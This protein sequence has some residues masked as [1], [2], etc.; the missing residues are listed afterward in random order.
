[1]GA[2]GKHAVSRSRWP[3]APVTLHEAVLSGPASSLSR[4]ASAATWPASRG[5]GREALVAPWAPGLRRTARQVAATWAMVS[6][7]G[8]DVAQLN[9]GGEA[10]DGLPPPVCCPER[11][12]H[13]LHPKPALDCSTNK[14]PWFIVGICGLLYAFTVWS[15]KLPWNSTRLTKWCHL[16]L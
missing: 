12:P 10:E 1:M 9:E 15:G 2:G 4:R 3:H 6:R 8:A 13:P 14:Y 16:V 11:A 7:P 5:S